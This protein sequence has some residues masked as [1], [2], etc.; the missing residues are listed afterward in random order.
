MKRNI[1]CIVVIIVFG[2]ILAVPGCGGSHKSGRGSSPSY[3][4][5]GGTG[6]GTGGTGGSN[7]GSAG[8]SGAA[9]NTTNDANT[10]LFT[11]QDMFND[12][13][14]FRREYSDHSPYDGYPWQGYFRNE[15]TWSR[16]MT[17]DDAL[18]DEAQAEAEA[19]RAGGSPKGERF[20]NQHQEHEP[21]WACGLDSP[22]FMITG[23]STN[24]LD[25]NM[26]GRWHTKANGT[27]REGIAYQT[28]TG[29]YC[30]KTML[31]VG[32]AD[33]ADNEIWWVL[34]FGE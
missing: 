15:M 18:A 19:V 9:A 21:F 8:G 14:N 16:T 24:E 31:G 22:K 32:K 26:H 20:P 12:I 29:E 4:S 13:N 11:V 23:K 17:W 33:L 2:L 10:G 27:A 28:G 3:G 7:G 30:H 6:T 25:G 5:T 1:V 34:I